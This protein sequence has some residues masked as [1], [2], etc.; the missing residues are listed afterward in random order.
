[1]VLMAGIDLP[2]RAIRQQIVGAISL[3]VEQTRFKDGTRKIVNITEVRG[4]EGDVIALRDIFTFKQ[5]KVD[6]N[7]KVVGDFVPTGVRPKFYDD[8]QAYGI[9]VPASIFNPEG[10]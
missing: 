9:Q 10:W 4:M 3:I 1:M 5:K 8:F 6:A 7:G 2:M